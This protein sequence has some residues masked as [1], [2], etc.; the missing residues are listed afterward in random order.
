M[1]ILVLAF[2]LKS[3]ANEILDDWF[4]CKMSFDIQAWNDP[5]SSSNI[6]DFLSF[7]SYARY[8]EKIT[9]PNM[10]GLYL[11]EQQH[12]FVYKSIDFEKAKNQ[13]ETMHK[14]LVNLGDEIIIKA[15]ESYDIDVDELE[16]TVSIQKAYESIPVG[17]LFQK[18][19]EKLR[20]TN[21][22]IN[23]ALIDEIPIYQ[24]KKLEGIRNH[25]DRQFK[26]DLKNFLSIEE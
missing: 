12:S 1:P 10:L 24:I 18:I 19:L 23:E 20:K 25:R 4:T 22:S 13:T 8:L 3:D 26:L 21:P 11:K 2:P 9:S 5:S 14:I 7:Y 16:A 6:N 17:N 15:I